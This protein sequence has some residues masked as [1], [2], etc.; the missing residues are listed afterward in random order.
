MI[1][2]TTFKADAIR[3]K[4]MGAM[5]RCLTFKNTQVVLN[6]NGLVFLS[7]ERWTVPGR[8]VRCFKFTDNSGMDVTEMVYKGLKS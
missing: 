5:R 8:V 3:C 1:T 4:I 2:S 6:R 7:I